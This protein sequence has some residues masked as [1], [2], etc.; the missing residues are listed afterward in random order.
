[1]QHAAAVHLLGSQQVVAATGIA[2]TVID[3]AGFAFVRQNEFV[4]I[5]AHFIT[6]V[7]EFSS[8]RSVVDVA[9]AVFLE[10]HRRLRGFR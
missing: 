1:M 3:P 10:D 6:G 5:D 7:V 8:V 4:T 2:A 9:G